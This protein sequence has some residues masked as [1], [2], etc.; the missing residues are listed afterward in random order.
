MAYLP[1]RLAH[2]S[3]DPAH[4]LLHRWGKAGHQPS[5]YSHRQGVFTI[6]VWFPKGWAG[7][8]DFERN[9]MYVDWFRF[10]PYDETG[11]EA[12]PRENLEF[13]MEG[14][15]HTYPSQT[16]PLPVNNFFA[17]G[18]FE[19]GSRAG[20]RRGRRQPPRNTPPT[21]RAARP[22]ARAAA[23]PSWFPASR[24]R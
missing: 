18:S 21:A 2:R 1:L 16:S 5:E 6:G 7:V 4:R 22:S 24:P 14:L 3:A 12:N 8:A 15:E 10:T 23:W 17:N 19:D 11:W 13:D 20:R 9:Y